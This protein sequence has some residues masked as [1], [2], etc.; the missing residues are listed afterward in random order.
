MRAVGIELRLAR[1]SRGM[2]LSQVAEQLP[3]G[4]RVPTLSGYETGT[5]SFHVG[6]FVE[7]CIALGVSAPNLLTAALHRAGMGLAAVGVV[8][9]LRLMADNAPQEL[10]PLRRWAQWKL[11]GNAEAVTMV[12]PA[13]IRDMAGFCGLSVSAMA[14]E[15]ERFAPT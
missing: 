11:E 1:Q 14:A 9:D 13:L 15:L 2:T 6:R 5:K 10:E 8:I 3:S 4:I 7:I 12:E